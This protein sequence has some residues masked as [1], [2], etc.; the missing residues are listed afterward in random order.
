MKR[1]TSGH[2]KL[3]VARDPRPK[4]VAIS[5]DMK[6][7]SALL[8]AEL[9]AWPGIMVK[10]MF[11]F[12]SLYRRTTIF[13]CLP[14]TRGFDSPSSLILKFNPMPAVLLK[15]A[16]ADSRMEANMPGKRWFAFRLNSEAD[17]RDALWWLSQAYEAAKKRTAR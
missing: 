16:R 13:A 4:F 3:R 12:W 17:L 2:P 6:H 11:G 15:R 5:D 7:W 8:I 9:N 14:R 1:K 10:S